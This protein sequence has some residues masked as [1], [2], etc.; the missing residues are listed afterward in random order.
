MTTV[1]ALARN[2]QIWM[3]A[4]TRNNVYDRPII[5]GA[6]KIQRRMVE[7]ANGD[8][9][10]GLAGDGCIQQLTHKLKV[11]YL[12]DDADSNDAQSWADAIATGITDIALEAAVTNDAGRMDALLLLGAVGRVWTLTHHQAIP[13]PDGIAAIGSGE[14]LAIGALEAMLSLDLGAEPGEWLVKRAVSIACQYDIY[15]DEPVE[16]MT[17]PSA[18]PEE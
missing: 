13:H 12:P 15:S 5:A 4:D 14:E 10:L 7:A 9:L 11:D 6:H 1:C 16:A 18:I 2:G 8:L 3:A 17:W